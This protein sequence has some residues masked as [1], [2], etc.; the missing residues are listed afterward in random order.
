MLFLLSNY[1]FLKVAPT[2]EQ[3][4]YWAD[5]LVPHVDYYINDVAMS[6]FKTF[7]DRELRLI[8]GNYVSYNFDKYNRQMLVGAILNVLGEMESD[9]TDLASLRIKLG[10]EYSE[11]SLSDVPKDK[12]PAK[13]RTASTGGR[14]SG[15]RAVIFEYAEKAWVEL[16]KPTDLSIIRKMRID[17]MNELE[18]IG[19]KRTTAS[20]TLGAWQKNLNLD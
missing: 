1:K 5:I 15:Q 6:S 10:R 4:F 8:L 19:V 16:G 7:D 3:L 11:P 13:S 14:S 2:E 17:V 18:Q 12:T 20:T 9:N